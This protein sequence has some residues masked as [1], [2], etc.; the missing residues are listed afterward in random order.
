MRNIFALVLPFLIISFSCSK[1]TEASIANTNDCIINGIDVCKPADLKIRINIDDEKQTI[2]HFG[3]SD[4]WSTKYVGNWANIQ[5][6]NQ[7]A[8]Y[9]FTMDTLSSGQPKGIGLSL[10]RFNIGAGSLEQGSSSG[11]ADEWRREECFLSPDGTY[12]WNKQSGQ[13]WFLD[14]AK[15][16]GINNFIAF[17]VA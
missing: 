16:R 3:A 12:D 1:K 10:W 9:L 7:I 14:A 17:S 8:D 13:Q 15:Q 6:K 4:C 5:K 2:E 11:I